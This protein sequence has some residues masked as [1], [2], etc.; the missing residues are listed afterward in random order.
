MVKL[1]AKKKERLCVTM[2]THNMSGWPE[3]DGI[4]CEM[5]GGLTKSC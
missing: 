2:G 1:P 3:S 4:E 5:V